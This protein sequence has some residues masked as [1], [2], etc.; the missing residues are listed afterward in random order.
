VVRDISFAEGPTF[1]TRGNLFF[2][3]YK[4]NGNIGRR[5]ILGQGRRADCET[6]GHENESHRRNPERRL[7]HQAER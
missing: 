7:H 6:D 2:V 1:D 3:N 5:D 4:G